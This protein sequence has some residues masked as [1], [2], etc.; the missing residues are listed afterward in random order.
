MLFVIE[1]H[2][3]YTVVYLYWHK[4][5]AYGVEKRRNLTFDTVSTGK[6]VKPITYTLNILPTKTRCCKICKWSLYISCSSSSVIIIY[7]IILRP[8]YAA[9]YFCPSSCHHSSLEWLIPAQ[10]V[11][12]GDC[13]HCPVV[14]IYLFSE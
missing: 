10:G 6:H 4:K 5:Y 11:S 3:L 2:N 8:D 9:F 12:I 13:V 7:Y 1:E 14:F